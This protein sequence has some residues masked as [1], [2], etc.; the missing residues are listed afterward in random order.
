MLCLHGIEAHGLRFLGMASY[1]PGVQV[2]APDLRGHGR[3]PMTGPWSLDQHVADLLPLLA[4]LGPD[5]VVLGHSYGGLVAW[6]LA[7]A[8]PSQLSGLVL[9]DPAIGIDP[10]FAAEGLLTALA[11][12]AATWPDHTAAFAD[13]VSGRSPNA[14]WSVALDVAVGLTVAPDGSVRPSVAR[15]AVQDCWT[16]LSAPLTETAYRGPTLV[17]DA[18]KENGLY[19]T[20]GALAQLRAQLGDL[21]QYVALDQP[22]TIPADAPAEL[23]AAVASFIEQIPVATR[24]RRD[25]SRS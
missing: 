1:L 21:M 17:I 23:A 20:P 10:E 8:A 22:H 18:A 5:T 7:G 6:A 4:E 9:V 14:H 15:G 12:T 11:G 16:R 25:A 3:S 13:L 19:L 2:V 24:R